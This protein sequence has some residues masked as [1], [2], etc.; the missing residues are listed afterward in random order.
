LQVENVVE[1]KN[2]G[3]KQFDDQVNQRNELAS[4]IGENLSVN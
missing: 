2:G 4:Q 3:M 1:S